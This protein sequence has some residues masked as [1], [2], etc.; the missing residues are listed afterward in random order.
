MLAKEDK[1]SIGGLKRV[2]KKPTKFRGS[3]SKEKPKTLKDLKDIE[4]EPENTFTGSY[5]NTVPT[6]TLT[7]EGKRYGKKIMQQSHSSYSKDIPGVVTGKEL[8]A[9]R[10]QSKQDKNRAAE[11]AQMK[12]GKW[13]KNEAR[14][15][16]LKE[17]GEKSEYAKQV[18][19][20]QARANA[21]SRGEVID[22]ESDLEYDEDDT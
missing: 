13:K 5:A 7:S 20:A 12:A 16:R 3:A 6:K 8:M 21:V 9:E 22:P 11:L 10:M 14:M 15:K 2:R 19:A 1:S 18:R 4:A 17:E